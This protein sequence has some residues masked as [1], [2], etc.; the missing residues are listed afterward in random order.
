MTIDYH[1]HDIDAL[2]LDVETRP[3][4][5][6]VIWWRTETSNGSSIAKTN[7]PL[8][9]PGRERKYWAEECC[10]QYSVFCHYQAIR[11]VWRKV[12]PVTK[13]IARISK[14]CDLKWLALRVLHRNSRNVIKCIASFILTICSSSITVLPWDISIVKICTKIDNIVKKIH[15]NCW[16]M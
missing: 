14:W 3:R 11:T 15:C 2:L 9:R 4:F 8:G 6:P 7:R 16:Y 12:F 1:F 13:F 10:F 5:R